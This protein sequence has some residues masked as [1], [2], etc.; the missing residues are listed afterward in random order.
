MGFIW[1]YESITVKKYLSPFN[2]VGDI[3]F[4]ANLF[5]N[6]FT[7]YYDHKEELVV[8]H[9]KIFTHYLTNMF[10]ID[11]VASFPM[12]LIHWLHKEMQLSSF[13]RFYLSLLVYLRVFSMVK[14]V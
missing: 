13:L 4:A 1:Y 14:K 11:L 5:V 6:C 10:I 9:W 8:T 2:T 12:I 7:T 3:L